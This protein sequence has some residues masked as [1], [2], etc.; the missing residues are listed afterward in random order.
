MPMKTVAH[1]PESP[2]LGSLRDPKWLIFS[3]LDGSLLDSR[4]NLPESNRDFLHHLQQQGIPVIFTSSKTRQ[5]ILHLQKDLNISEPFIPENGGGIYFPVG[6]PITEKLELMP[7][8]KGLG[9][10]FGAP[11]SYIRGVFMQLQKHFGIMGMADMHPD[12]LMELTGLD[13]KAVNRALAREFTEPF[14]FRGQPMP[15]QLRTVVSTY[16]LAI[17]CGGRFFHMMSA[18]QDKGQAV[19]KTIQLFRLA[20]QHSPC[21]VAL[22]DA[23]NDFSMFHAVDQAILL[24]R[25]DGSIADLD[26]PGLRRAECSGCAGWREQ[27]EL[28]I[29]QP[30]SVLGNGARKGQ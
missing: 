13:A 24:R 5:E 29:K 4:G 11:Y 26:L 19:A 9:L 25:D 30:G 15:C 12:E 20:N 23:E 7:W 18:T 14:I 10:H 28:L 17:T 21:T 6:H 3:D 8:G 16:G 22:G 27:L 2:S 1:T